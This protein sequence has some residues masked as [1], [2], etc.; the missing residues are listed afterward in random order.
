MSICSS[1][2]QPADN[3][4]RIGRI[5]PL[6]AQGTGGIVREVLPD[7]GRIDGEGCRQGDKVRGCLRRGALS[8]MGSPIWKLVEIDAYQLNPVAKAVFGL[9]SVTFEV[10]SRH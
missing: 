9:A 3:I 4:L 8:Y 6:V 2:S 10:R 7:D 5:S 1:P